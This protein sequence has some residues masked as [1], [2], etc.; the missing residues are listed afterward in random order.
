[1]RHLTTA[2][3]AA[4]FL[5]VPAAASAQDNASDGPFRFLGRLILAAGLSPAPEAAVPRAVTVVTGEDMR[6][7]GIDQLA[8]ALRFVPGIA[9]SRDSGP[10]GMTQL[11]MRGTETRHTQIILDGV[12]IDTA[13]D[14]YADLGG[15]QAADIERI[16]VIRGPQSAFFGSNSIGGVVSITTR[17]ATEPGVSGQAGIEAGSDGTVGLDFQVGFR[18]ARGGLTLSGIARNDGGWDISDSPGGRRDG[19]RNRTLTLSGDWQVT[20]AWRAGFMLRARNQGYDFDRF[21]FGAPTV[22]GIIVEAD[23]T[24]VVQ[25]R[26]GSV[27]AEGDLAEGRL[28]LSLRAS[29]FRLDRKTF[30][31]FPSDTTTDRT[32]FAVRGV[33]ALDGGTLDTARH[34]LGFG[35]DRMSEG[36][37]NNDPALVFNPNQLIRQSRRVIGVALDYRGELAEGLD[38]QAGV[39]RDLNDAFRD[40]TTWSLGLSYAIPATG[41]RLRVSGGTA[42][43][44]PTLF[45]QF[46]FANTFVGNPDLRPERSRG[47]DIGVDQSIL[48][49]QGTVSVT[50]FDNRIFDL[51]GSAATPDGTTPVNVVGTSRQRGAELGLDAQVHDRVRLRAAYTYTRARNPAGE[52]LLRRP[53]HEATL[54]VD[55]QATDATRVSLDLRRVVDNLDN[56]FS[57]FVGVPVRLPDYTLVNLSASH[58]INDRLELTARVNNLTNRRYQEV[59]GYAT[60]PRTAYVGLRSSF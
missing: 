30:D 25:E 19:L 15:L 57:T 21:V 2:A 46:G 29:S 9:I 49:G 34:T 6:A 26:I 24:G 14:G 43:Q 59:L 28:R 11:R 58:R 39:R 23:Y 40:A 13:Q 52:R 53:R 38:V 41:T 48:G 4:A 10:G 55:W 36:F 50:L 12:R 31:G 22:P 32:E 35:V 18:E 47:W 20:E 8:D 44:N 51:I 45:A 27:F 56:E 1:M 60:Q 3:A 16:E 17:R 37:V 33:W 7:R 42:V 54:G 5:T